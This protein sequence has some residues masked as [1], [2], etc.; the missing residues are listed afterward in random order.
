MRKY[1]ILLSALLLSVCSPQTISLPTSTQ[2]NPPT[3]APTVLQSPAVQQDAQVLSLVIADLSTR[4]SLDQDLIHV[5]STKPAVW[6]DNSL[7]C[8][9]P[10][11]VYTQQMVTGYQV[12]LEANDQIYIYHTDNQDSIILCEEKEQLPSFP[13]TPGEIDDGQPWMP[14]D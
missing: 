3:E 9:S 4:L 2:I 14:V 10:G 7:G 1:L 6:P 8:P 12:W 13:V 11:E 5:L